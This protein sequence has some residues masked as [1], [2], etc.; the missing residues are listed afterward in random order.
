[1]LKT[2]RSIYIRLDTIPY[3]DGSTT[4]GQTAGPTDGFA[5]ASTA[6]SIAS[7][8]DLAMRTRCKN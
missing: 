8:A 1:M 6:L 2:S 3:H 5:L 7:N 4:D